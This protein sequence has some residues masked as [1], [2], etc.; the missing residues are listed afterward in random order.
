VGI[1]F[2][3]ETRIMVGLLAAPSDPARSW[4]WQ[5][6]TTVDGVETTIAGFAPTENDAILRAAALTIDLHA[7]ARPVRPTRVADPRYHEPGWW[8][9]LEDKET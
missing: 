1:E 9:G 4:W 7:Q 6:T 2:V 5:S 8:P 3:S